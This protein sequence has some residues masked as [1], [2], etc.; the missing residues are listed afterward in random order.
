MLSSAKPRRAQIASRTGFCVDADCTPESGKPH[1]SPKCL[2]VIVDRQKMH[3][4]D[5]SKPSKFRDKHFLA[6]VVSTQPSM[7]STQWLRAKVEMST[8]N[9]GRSTLDGSPRRPI[10][11]MAKA[12][13]HEM[14]SGQVDTTPS[15]V[16]TL[17][18]RSTLTSSSVDTDPPARFFFAV[19][20]G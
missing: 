14:I 8:P 13:R 2:P 11:Q 1:Q 16:D 4:N 5:R 12:G 3:H 18:L 9:A 15:S 7:V 20:A 19:G 10:F 17:S 6:K